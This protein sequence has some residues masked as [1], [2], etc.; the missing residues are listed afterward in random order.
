M[1]HYNNKTK[2]RKGET[3]RK[4]VYERIN[5]III[6]ALEQEIIPWESP[7]N[8][9]RLDMLPHNIN[10]RKYRGCNLFLLG[11]V[12]YFKQYRSS[13][14]LTFNQ[15]KELGG[16]VKKSEKAMP[17]VFWKKLE[18]KEDQTKESGEISG[19]DLKERFVARY[20]LVFNI[21]QTEGIEKLPPELA[22]LEA[23]RAASKNENFDSIL[24]AEN[25]VQ[26]YH[27]RPLV[28][29]RD[30]PRN[31]YSPSKDEI[32][33]DLHENFKSEYH[34]YKTLFHELA[35]ST[36]HK[37]RLGRL[38]SKKN[39]A[40]GSIE[41]GQE[42]L[43]AE[44][45]SAYISMIIGIE[46]P[47]AE[48]SAAYCQNWLKAIKGDKKMFVMAASQAQKAADYIIGEN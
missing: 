19:E 7:N 4:D 21:D 27:D 43:V 13:Y 33:L 14:W 37:C 42:E 1:A 26:G 41:Y 16:K 36:G 12:G 28:I 17:V 3:S 44:L 5:E 29:H 34:Y 25:I 2:Y 18:P 9:D 46:T 20:Y 8:V 31:F 10:G 45:T 11:F 24:E 15:V 6:E 35:H 47:K 23:K 40:F 38:E 32:E 48:N 39:A 22:E 30:N